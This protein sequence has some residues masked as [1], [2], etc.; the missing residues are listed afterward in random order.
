MRA[1]VP[2]RTVVKSGE[3]IRARARLESARIKE[4][5]YYY[6]QISLNP[7]SEPRKEPE[8]EIKLIL[9]YDLRSA[10][11][12]RFRDTF[13]GEPAGQGGRSW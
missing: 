13:R 8:G 3:P 7:S 1:S 12:D 6:Q 11:P 10:G 9:P 4:R 2:L 5:Y